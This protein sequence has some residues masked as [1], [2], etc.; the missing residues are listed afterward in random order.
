MIG[1]EPQSDGGTTSAHAE[2]TFLTFFLLDQW[3]NY[4]RAR[5]EYERQLGAHPQ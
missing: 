3:G 2:N 1:I 5:G 4:L